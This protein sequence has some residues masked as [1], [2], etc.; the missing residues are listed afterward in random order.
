MATDA[1]KLQIEVLQNIPVT[2]WTVTTDGQLDFVNR[3]YLE[4]MGQS[5]EAYTLPLDEW[6]KSGSD[7]PP[8]LSNLHPEYK[9]SVRKKFWESVRSGK[10]WTFEAPFLHASDGK[11]H[12]HIDRAVP[13]RDEHG[14]VVRFVGSCADIDDLKRAQ[15]Q[16]KTACEEIAALKAKLEEENTYLLE[17]LHKAH[18]FTEIIGSSPPILRLLE[19]VEAAAPTD[20][21]VLI[22]GETGSGKE[23]IARA[24][25]SRSNRK[26][27]ALVKVNCGAIPADLVESELFGHVKGAFTGAS[28]TRVGRFELADGSTLFLDEIG[29]LP[30]ATQVKLLRVLQEQQFEP[31]GSN[32]TIKVDVRIIAAT[33]RDLE[34][35][36]KSGQFRSD[37]YYRLNVIPLRVPPLRERGSDIPEMVVRFVEQASMRVGKMIEGV[38]QETMRTLVDYSWPGNVRELQNVIERGV[39]LSKRTVLRLGSDLLP[40]HSLDEELSAAPEAAFSSEQFASLE[41]IEKQHILRVLDSTGWLISGTDGAAAILKLHPNT[42]R[43]RMKK[44]GISRPDNG[45]SSLSRSAAATLTK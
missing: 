11:Y 8:F 45:I 28:N 1:V 39:I 26:G 32:R 30:L 34:K 38:S 24:V 5:L 40:D 36:V 13:L 16:S 18:N 42:L 37:L 21:N 6:N 3:Y 2:A 23:L 29:E 43:S 4:I 22:L 27:R 44:L 31:V 14:D 20:A 7:L 10:G 41:E 19:I 17:E 12:W 35:A 15:E 9:E 33:N 25:H